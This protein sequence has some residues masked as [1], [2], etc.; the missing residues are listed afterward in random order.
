MVDS[1][2][3]Y[4]LSFLDAF[5]QREKSLTFWLP[6]LLA[7]AGAVL[8]PLPLVLDMKVHVGMSAT[9]PVLWPL[10]ILLVIGSAILAAKSGNRHLAKMALVAAVAG[11][12]ATATY[13][14]T[15]IM[16]MS[17]GVTPMDEAVDFGLRITGQTAPGH[18]PTH[19]NE[20]PTPEARSGDDHRQTARPDEHAGDAHQGD[21][22]QP[23]VH[24]E[25]APARQGSTVALGY[26]WHYS[27]GLMFSLGYLVL[28]GARRWPWAIPYM[29]FVIYSGMIF[30]MGVHSMAN[31]IWEAVGHA[32]F[33]LTLGLVTWAFLGGNEPAHA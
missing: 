27:N 31:F 14:A 30:A 6:H 3:I 22:H 29:V 32:A 18:G 7:L 11:Y 23:D 24:Q 9:V 4:D 33:G 16:G 17:A 15:R 12:M 8:A 2:R 20:Q 21:V 19:G 26:A 5:L 13:D 1:V 25:A 28:F 10:S